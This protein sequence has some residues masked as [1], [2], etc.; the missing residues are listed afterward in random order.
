MQFDFQAKPLTS[1]RPWAIHFTSLSL[2]V[3]IGKVGG[4]FLSFWE[5]VKIS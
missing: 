5:V 4:I 1:F 3:S 2:N